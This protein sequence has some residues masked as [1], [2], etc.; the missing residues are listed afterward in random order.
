MSHSYF[1]NYLHTM[2]VFY[3]PTNVQSVP[4]FFFVSQII[5]R[6]SV[7]N[8]TRALVQGLHRASDVRVYINRVE[9]LSYHLLEFP[10]TSVVAVK[11]RILSGLAFFILFILSSVNT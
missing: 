10:E 3:E 5:A 2:S 7:D 4:L 8:R 11:V 6:V 1:L 9:D